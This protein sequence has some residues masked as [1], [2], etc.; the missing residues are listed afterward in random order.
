MS[1][2]VRIIGGGWSGLAAAVELSSQN[3]PV[4][5]YESAKQLG[6]RARSIQLNNTTL[7]NGQHLM[8]GAY[9]TMLAL[10]TKIGVNENDVF[11]RMPQQLD[12]LD[13][14]TRQ[15][16]FKLSL[17]SWPA[18]WHLLAGML[19]CP[20]LSLIEKFSTLIGFNTLL[21]KNIEVDISVDQ[22][23]QQTKIPQ[24]YIQFLLKPLCLAALTTHTSTASARAFQTVLQQTFNGP[25]CNTDLLIPK[26]DLGKLF[27]QAAK[28]YIEQHGGKVLLE[29]R[30]DQIHFEHTKAQSLSINNQSIPCDHII[31][32]TPAHIAQKL[33][34]QS[35]LLQTSRDKIN[36]IEYEPVITVYIQYANTVQLPMP[37]LGV[38]NAYSE[39]LFDRRYCNQAGLI[40]VV[41]SAHG[42]HME[43]DNASLTRHISDELSQLFPHWPEPL[44]ASAIRE[45][46][47]CFRCTTNIDKHRPQTTTAVNN[48]TLCGD[49]VYIEE[50]NA[51][52]LPSTLEGSL[53]SGVKCAQNFIQDHL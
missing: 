17:P 29:H 53:R 38:I 35:E 41:I 43:L 44:S 32:A 45:K 18:P 52:G 30:V 48:L 16:V 14:T 4:T 23:L 42:P 36:H 50:K 19:A 39:W 49:Y 47:A 31:L 5:V 33:L 8:I 28:E 2:H 27:P 40:A 37:M 22:W 25:A 26:V 7:D 6:G 3:I 21:K 34:S 51:A 12:M 24:K 15:S 11:H 13:L 10:L 1:K 9:Q 46:R 20:S